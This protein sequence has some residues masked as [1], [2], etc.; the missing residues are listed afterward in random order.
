MSDIVEM[1]LFVEKGLCPVLATLSQLP[2]AARCRCMARLKLLQ[3]L[4]TEV[5]H[6]IN[7]DLPIC[8]VRVANGSGNVFILFSTHASTIVLLHAVASLGPLDSEAV[9]CATTRHRLFVSNPEKHTYGE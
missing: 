5:G 3:H 4:G 9:S 2:G 1:R 8:Y 6:P 7:S